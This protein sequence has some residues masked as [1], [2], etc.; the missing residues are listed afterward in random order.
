MNHKIKE[1]VSFDEFII[2]ANEEC[3]WLVLGYFEYSLNDF[4][5]MVKAFIFSVEV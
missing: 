2:V 4:L 3:D 5:K 1:W